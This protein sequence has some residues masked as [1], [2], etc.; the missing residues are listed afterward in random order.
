MASPSSAPKQ[1]P[2]ANPIQR[3]L[4]GGPGRTK[5]RRR[6][7][8]WR[9]RR[10]LL[11]AVLFGVGLV[12]G[13]LAL[14]AREELPE[15][16][17]AQLAQTSYVCTADIATEC[18]VDVAV[19]A[20]SAGEDREIVPYSAIPQVTLDAVVAV[21]D[22]NFFNDQ[23]GIDPLG[24]GRALYQNTREGRAAQGGSTIT[25]QYV[26]NTYD[27]DADRNIV[28]KLKE[29]ALA[30]KLTRQLSREEILG[31]YM[32]RIYFGRGAY[33]IQ[34][35]AQAYYGKNVEELGLSESAFLA[36]LI[37]APSSAEPYRNPDEANRR[38]DV[39]LARMVTDGYISQVEAD[40]IMATPVIETVIV[41]NDRDGFGAVLGQ[42]DGSEYFLEAVRQEL[43]ELEPE[44]GE[45]FT[46]G[47]RVYTT[48]DPQMQQAA[49]LS[50]TEV[51]DPRF[52]G[53]L[54]PSGS[55]VAIDDRGRVV[56]MM[57]GYDF[58][59]SQVNLATGVDGGGSGRQPGSS[60][61][62]FALAEALEQGFSAESLYAAP[63]TIEIPEANDGQTWTVG[64]G[65]SEDGY[66]DLLDALRVSSNVV[67]AQLMVDLSPGTVVQ[68]ANN[69]GV[70]ADLP[71]VNAL[72]L[73][74]GEVSVLDMA[75]SYSTIA[76][77][78]VRYEPILIERIEDRDGNV[79]CWYP[80]NGTCQQAEGREGEPVLDGSIA[81]QVTFA[82]QQVVESGTGRN[83][84]FGQPAAGKTGT[85][86]D[87]RDAWFVGFTCEL[88]TAVWMGYPGL[89]EGEPLTMENFR[90]IEVHGGDFPAEIWGSFNARA[91]DIRAGR[92]EAP[93][94]GLATQADFP[95]LVLNPDLST[96]TL[97]FCAPAPAAPADGEAATAETAAPSSAP[98]TTA[99]GDSAGLGAVTTAPCVDPPPALLDADGQPVPTTPD[100]APVPTEAGGSTTA[101]AATAEGDTTT[102]PPTTAAE[103]TTEQPSTT[104]VPADSGEGAGEGD[105]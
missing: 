27:I 80:V 15:D 64:G 104:A 36:G 93:C 84:Q 22:K 37:R 2:P 85:T 1:Q 47:L 76:N 74:S 16:D 40:E 101:P 35:A 82:L 9:F 29:A 94:T 66:R 79:I 55:L 52:D 6:N 96:T 20:L 77:Q 92:G 88:S 10:F 69:L 67:Y 42:E 4:L 30:V 43:V 28:T 17:F 41:P 72:V 63:F 13:G 51:V 91:A 59:A 14:L 99:D 8:L 95:G 18:D 19:M 60:F 53:D 81:R 12:L 34:A 71:E 11:L 39:S 105:G 98:T 75:A 89:V 103:S 62:T 83:A 70:S 57:G 3:V 87:A 54:P 50:V 33:G 38:R 26:K 61:K 32:N 65:G 78:G 49:F 90:G 25:Q 56:A 58:E 7:P 86:Q 5:N 46:S 31:R 21:E 97:P 68:M 44:I 100:G 48:L 102:T 24:I 73:G 23:I 45:V